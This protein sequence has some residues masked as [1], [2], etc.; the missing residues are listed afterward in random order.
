IMMLATLTRPYERAVV[1]ALPGFA[2]APRPPPD[3]PFAPMRL[4]VVDAGRHRWAGPRL[5]LTNPPWL[6]S[7]A[8]RSSRPAAPNGRAP[9]LPVRLATTPRRRALTGPFTTTQLSFLPVGP[10]PDAP[11]RD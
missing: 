6:L 5:G 11:G 1:L 10:S 8:S 9:L 7:P 2:K 4:R 3:R